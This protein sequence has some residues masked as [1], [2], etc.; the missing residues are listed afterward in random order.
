MVERTDL[1]LAVILLG[2][3]AAASSSTPAGSIASS[4]FG[5]FTLAPGETRSINMG[6]LYRELRIC[7]DSSSGGTLVATVSGTPIQLV[8]G[9]CGV[10]NGSSLTLRNLSSVKVVG[11][12]T[13]SS[14]PVFELPS[15]D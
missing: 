12:Y 13:S 15:H 10:H 2:G 5:S 7:N 11:L 8:P 3:C 6:S 1:L 4:G 14:G 9:V